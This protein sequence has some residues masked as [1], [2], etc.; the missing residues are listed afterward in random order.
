MVR[1]GAADAREGTERKQV[2]AG[3]T[4]SAEVPKQESQRDSDRVDIISKSIT[5]NEQV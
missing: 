5:W 3:A 2:D 4:E 1:V